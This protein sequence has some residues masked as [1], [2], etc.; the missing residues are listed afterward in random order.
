[1]WPLKTA[2][3]Y[4]L[5]A[6]FL[7]SGRTM[8]CWPQHLCRILAAPACVILDQKTAQVWEHT[9]QF[10]K[11]TVNDCLIFIVC[12]TR[13]HRTIV[14]LA[15]NA[16]GDHYSNPLLPAF[17]PLSCPLSVLFVSTISLFLGHL[18][19]KSTLRPLKYLK[20]YLPCDTIV[21]V[22]VVHLED[23][24]STYLRHTHTS[25]FAILLQ[26]RK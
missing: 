5:T 15:N 22:L 3:S 12:G 19:G 4:A 14:I 23:F 13:F 11:C 25:V 26:C 24:E 18:P 6:L 2:D 20:I 17:L 1:M 9:T 10:W 7:K 21:L 16:L 8:P